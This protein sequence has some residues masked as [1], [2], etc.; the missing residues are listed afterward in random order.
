MVSKQK[1]HVNSL[2]LTVYGLEEYNQLP[3]GTSVAV[4]FALHGRL[5]N[6]SKMDSVSQAMCQSNERRQKGDRHILVVTF[7]LP[8]HGTRLNYKL[9]N[10]AWKEGKHENPNHAVDMWGV[11]Y[12]ASRTVSELIDVLECYLFGPHHWVEVW[13]VMGFSMGGHA[14][15]LTA[16]ND[17]RITVAIPIVGTSDYIALM[18][19]RLNEAQ[20]P[21]ETYLPDSFC[22]M[23]LRRTA[24]LDMKLK[25]K[26]VLIINAEK[27]TLVSARFN[28]PL[29]DSLRQVHVGREG[30]DWR[31]DL[32]PDVGHEW[33]PY[34]IDVTVQ[35]CQQWLITNNHNELSKI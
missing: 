33:C 35:W 11:V 12:S 7:D 2:Q 13:G 26:H 10:Y 27:D 18:K 8:N 31:Y 16:A 3:K 29:I 14:T 34:M 22:E 17:P 25:T 23:V 15:F 28:H 21:A 30:R 19:S 1:I 9:A 32:V 5:Q 6:Q 4:M 24:G 20:L